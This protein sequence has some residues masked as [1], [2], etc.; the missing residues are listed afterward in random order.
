[1]SLLCSG[2][3]LPSAAQLE[4]ASGR[5][6]E[7]CFHDW[8][9][10]RDVSGSADESDSSVA[11]SGLVGDDSRKWITPGA[12]PFVEEQWNCRN[13]ARLSDRQDCASGAQ[14]AMSR[15]THSAGGD[16]GDQHGH[17]AEAD[18]RGQGTQAQWNDELHSQRGRPL[19]CGTECFAAFPGSLGVED[20]C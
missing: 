15:L 6:T 17:D 19:L 9:L 13:S 3:C 5:S 14:G 11:Q 12:A 8:F 1:M 20:G 4:T 10:S 7:K 16:H 2:E 18:E